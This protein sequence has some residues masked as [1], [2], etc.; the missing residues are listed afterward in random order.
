MIRALVDGVLAVVL[1]VLFG[2]GLLYHFLWQM[3]SRQVG[4]GAVKTEKAA[5]PA[6]AFSPGPPPAR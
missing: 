6:T 3:P 5:P 4:Q 1:A 2:G